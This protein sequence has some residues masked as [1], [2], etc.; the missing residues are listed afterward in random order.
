M[1]GITEMQYK[2]TEGLRYPVLEEPVSEAKVMATLGKYGRMAARD[3][4]ENDPDRY[5]MMLLT[6]MLLPKMQE[7]EKEA[8]RMH[9]T[10]ADNLVKAWMEREKVDPYNTMEMTSLRIQAEMQAEEEVIKEVI[11]QS[12]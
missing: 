8:E 10:L 11:H 9:E 2:E 1:A 4:Q 7:V 3:L 6:G 12:R 5:E